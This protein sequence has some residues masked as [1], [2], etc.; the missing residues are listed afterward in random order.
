M[1][2][3]AGVPLMEMRLNISRGD[4]GRVLGAA[5][6]DA[7]TSGAEVVLQSRRPL[8]RAGT[9][10]LTASRGRTKLRRGTCATS[11]GS[12]ASLTRCYAFPTLAGRV[13]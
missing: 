10:L 3:F 13:S 4:S 8:P 7:C 12:T 2:P 6:G 5:T 9:V 11:R 1:Y